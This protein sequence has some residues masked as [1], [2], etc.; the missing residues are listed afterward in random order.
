[1]DYS[2]SNDQEMIKKAAKEFFEKECPKEKVRELKEDPKGFDP[3]MWKKMVEL[4]YVGL[5]IPEQFGGTEGDFVELAVF[6]EEMGRNIAPSPFYSTG[7]LCAMPLIEFG[8]EEQQ[9]KYL[10]RIAEKGDIWSFAQTEQKGDYEADDIKMK[11]VAE[12]EE[13]VLN[14]TKL[15]VP[16][17]TS[18][19][20]FLV[21]ARTADGNDPQQGV[22]LFIVDAKSA[23]IS[24]ELMPTAAR[25]CRCEVQFA[26][27]KVPKEN[28]LG[29][30]NDGWKIVDTILQYGAVAKAAEMSGGA[31]QAL[32][33]AV[34]YAR[35]RKQFGK[36]IGSFQAIQHT[37][38]D[39]L[40]HVDGLKYLVYEA[41]WKIS[42][43]TPSKMLN[44]MVKAKANVVYHQVGYHGMVTHGAIGWTEEMDIGLYHLRTKVNQF[45]GG[46]TDLHLERIAGELENM[47]PD[48][49]KLYG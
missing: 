39:L 22:S 20:T 12:G 28:L 1:M 10:P 44:S 32:T 2:L 14:G 11:A 34:D 8:T 26:D 31:Q 33:I 29:D 7:V 17:A 24:I 45:D 16:F 23:G 30:L 6:A 27:V 36:S 43:G 42:Q 4:G 21:V 5:I 13:F 46:G 47:E 40:T 38:V 15:F 49:M 37:L 9:K 19:K 41:A 35:E 18:A 3:K 48:Y 25:D